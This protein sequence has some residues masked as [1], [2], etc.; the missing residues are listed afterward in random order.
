MSHALAATLG[1][2]PTRLLIALLTGS[3]LIVA[4]I[5]GAPAEGRG[6]LAADEPAGLVVLHGPATVTLDDT[7]SDGHRIGDVRVGSVPTTDAEGRYAIEGLAPGSYRLLAVLGDFRISD[8]YHI[9][10]NEGVSLLAGD[11]KTH[12]FDLP[13]GRVEITLLDAE[14]GK[15][16]P[17]GLAIGRAVDR[18]H[19]VDRFEGFR[20]KLGWAQAADA[21]GVVRL[22]CL[23]TDTDLMVRFGTREPGYERGEQTVRAGSPGA[24]HR[25][26]VKLKKK[27]N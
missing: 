8:D 13:G 6:D 25:I 9:V 20:A 12:D 27:A 1:R 21:K 23:P 24:P 19:G 10:S 5:G 2:A 26:E 4:L 17:G 15:P 18:T 14:T 7:T 22:R 16:V 11:L 3:A